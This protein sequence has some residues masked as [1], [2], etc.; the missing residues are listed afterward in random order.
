MS[1]ITTIQCISDLET[2]ATEWEE[3]FF[4]PEIGYPSIWYRGQPQDLPPQPVVLR[5]KFLGC[6]EDDEI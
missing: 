2:V 5:A 3:K 1:A 6:C 4:E